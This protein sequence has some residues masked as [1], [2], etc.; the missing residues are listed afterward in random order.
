VLECNHDRE[1]LA[2]SDYPFALKQRIAGRYGHLHNEGGRGLLAALDQLAP[3]A[4]H[5]G[6]PVAAEQHAR[7]GAARAGGALNCAPDWIGVADQSIGF[8]W[9]NALKG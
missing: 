3:Q 5:R 4:R 2:D 9:R 8:D 1:M 6:A 7:Q